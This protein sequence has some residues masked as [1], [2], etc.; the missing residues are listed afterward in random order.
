[1]N[2]KNSQLSAQEVN[3]VVISRPDTGEIISISLAKGQSANLNFDASSAIPLVEGNNF[4]LT[5]DNTDDG[6]A[7]SRIV[8]LNLVEE[9][10]GPDAPVLIIKE[11]RYDANVLILQTLVLSDDSDTLETASGAAT[12]TAG[13][14]GSV[15]NDDLGS[16][17]NLLAA[18]GVIDPTELAFDLL[19]PIPDIIPLLKVSSPPLS[20]LTP[21]RADEVITP[22]QF[23]PPFPSGEGDGGLYIPDFS[24]A[25][26]DLG[27]NIQESGIVLFKQLDVNGSIGDSDDTVIGT[28]GGSDGET[29]LE[30]LVFTLLTFPQYGELILVSNGVSSLMSIGDTFDNTST[31]WWFATSDQFQDYLNSGDDGDILPTDPEPTFN[32][33][34]TD[35]DGGV[36]IETVTITLL[37]FPSLSDQNVGSSEISALSFYDVI[38]TN[39][40]NGVVPSYLSGGVTDFVEDFVPQ[41]NPGILFTDIS[42]DMNFAHDVYDN[43]LIND[44]M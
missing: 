15:Y 43:S 8:F 12:G 14:G 6:N 1:M 4:I 30:D 10:Q 9:S 22:A 19:E 27:I 34:V 37:T 35:E 21:P 36:A 42:G 7:D 41:N 23:V 39:D 25:L 13:G 16:S 2:L 20:P 28:F 31:V 18:Q 26:D 38:D 40:D 17:I 3:S 5:F 32:Y 44:G 33:S 24:E 29:A 11:V